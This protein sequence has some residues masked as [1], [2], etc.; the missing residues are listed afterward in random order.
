MDFDGTDLSDSC[1]S[2]ELPGFPGVRAFPGPAPG[3]HVAP[4]CVGAGPYIDDVRVAGRN[5]DRADGW[6]CQVSIAYVLPTLSIVGCL[7]DAASGGPEKEVSRSLC[8]AGDR[9]DAPTTGWADAPVA[10]FI[11]PSGINTF[12]GSLRLGLCV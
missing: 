3:N 2:D 6:C 11:E 1:E 7:V 9:C 12:R 4:D 8:D 5:S 10:E